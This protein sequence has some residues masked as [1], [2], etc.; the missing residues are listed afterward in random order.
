MD[1]FTPPGGPGS[2]QGD[3]M[4]NVVGDDWSSPVGK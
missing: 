4:W 3:S 2:E 1:F